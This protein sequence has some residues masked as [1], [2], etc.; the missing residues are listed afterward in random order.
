MKKNR[1]KLLSL[2]LFTPLLMANSPAPMPTTR[3]YED[4]S[5]NCTLLSESENN[6]RYQ[7]E[8]TNNGEEYISVF[9]HYGFRLNNRSVYYS[10]AEGKLFDSEMIIPHQ[11]KTYIIQTYDPLN[12]D[13]E[14]RWS[15]EIYD[16]KDENVTFANY[17]LVKTSNNKYSLK[18][19]I[20]GE[21]DYYYAGIIEVTYDGVDYAFE[22]DLDRGDPYVFTNEELDLTKLTINKITAYRSSYNTYKANIGGF[23]KA[24]AIGIGI[25]ALI[26][27]GVVSLIVFAIVLTITL[28]DKHRQKNKTI[29][30]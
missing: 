8:I 19:D 30:K 9:Y 29:S 26:A 15:T 11:T 10:E 16:M 18:S 24:L 2:L 22:V 13:G 23:V 5:V 3:N 25:I 28:I 14:Q 1:A 4:F 7:L 6:Y 17:S 27:F 12:L 21:G 20:E